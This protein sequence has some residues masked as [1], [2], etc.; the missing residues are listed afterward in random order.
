MVAMC[1]CEEEERSWEERKWRRKGGF[2]EKL[3]VR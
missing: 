1:A 2:M 3:G